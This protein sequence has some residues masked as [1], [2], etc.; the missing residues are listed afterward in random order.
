MKRRKETKKNL[1][2]S[3]RYIIE[4][5][6]KKQ[7]NVMNL[8]YNSNTNAMPAY[9]IKLNYIKIRANNGETITE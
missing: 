2:V 8:S 4:L 6:L 9:K 3:H 7:K 5:E 1:H